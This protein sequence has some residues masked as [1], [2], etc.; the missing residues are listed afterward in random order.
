MVGAGANQVHSRGHTFSR[1]DAIDIFLTIA[2]LNAEHLA[3]VRQWWSSQAPNRR[4]RCGQIPEALQADL[5]C[6]DLAEKIFS[7]SAEANQSHLRTVSPTEGRIAIVTNAGWDAVDAAASGALVVAGRIG[8]IR[9]RT[10]GR[11]G[12][13]ALQRLLQNFG[14]QHMAGWSDVEG[15]CVRRSRVVLASVADV[16]WAERHRPNRAF[17]TSSIRWRRWQEE[18]VAGESKK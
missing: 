18:F 7:F 17:D 15:R 5:A 1:W 16:K 4:A 3:S 14:R 13:T 8:Q 6:P 10:I 2:W 11:A 12:R 9:E